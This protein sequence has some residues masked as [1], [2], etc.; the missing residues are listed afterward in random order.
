MTRNIDAELE[1]WIDYDQPLECT[2][3]KLKDGAPENI[4]EKFEK[5]KKIHESYRAK[6]KHTSG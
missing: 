3:S 6:L 1:S 4:K 2:E 5:W